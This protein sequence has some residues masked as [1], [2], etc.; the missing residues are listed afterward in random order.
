MMN[1]SSTKIRVVRKSGRKGE[2]G[3]FVA[4]GMELKQHNTCST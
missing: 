2:M 3:L 4:S 1:I